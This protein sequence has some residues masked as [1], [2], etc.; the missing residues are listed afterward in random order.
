MIRDDD[1][2][3]VLATVELVDEPEH[4]PWMDR[5]LRY[6]LHASACGRFAAVV[7][8]HG[9]YGRVV[10]LGRGAVVT[11]ALDGGELTMRCT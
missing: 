2:F 10:D 1:R 6:R 4:A 7:N 11:L 5:R 9:R 3:T 8:G